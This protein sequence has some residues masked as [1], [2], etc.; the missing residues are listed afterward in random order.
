M[1]WSD[2]GVSYYDLL[3]IA[4]DATPEEIKKAY[5]RYSTVLHPDKQP[6][7]VLKGEASAYF[8]QIKEAYEVPEPFSNRF[9]PLHML[10]SYF[11]SSVLSISMQQP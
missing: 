3:C 10:R 5:R 11:V 4:K 8:V 9:N 1:D 2:N 7:D 6:D